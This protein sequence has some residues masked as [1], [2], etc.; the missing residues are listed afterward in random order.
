MDPNLSVTADEHVSPPRAKSP[1]ESDISNTK[2]GLAPSNSRRSA[3]DG[4][5]GEHRRRRATNF[6]E[7]LEQW[8]RDE[9]EMLLEGV[10]GH[11]VVFPTRFLEGEDTSNNF[12]F[13]SDR[14]LPMPIYN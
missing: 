5:Q 2:S 11:L 6:D 12:L 1:A 3:T 4:S 9:F 14:L 10:R 7:P 8:E 13:N